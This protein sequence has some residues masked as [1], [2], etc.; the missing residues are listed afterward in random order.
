MLSSKKVGQKIKVLRKERGI[1]QGMLAKALGNK[2]HVAVSDIESGKSKI[3]IDDLSKIA[4]F[5][6]VPISTLL[7][8]PQGRP[9]PPS[10]AISMGLARSRKGLDK[11]TN[12]KA[13]ELLDRAIQ[14]ARSEPDAKTK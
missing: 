7:V 9:K 10:P 8:S 3:K 4:D 6:Q 11:K 1:S 13:Q 2:S 14:L 5:F 12:K